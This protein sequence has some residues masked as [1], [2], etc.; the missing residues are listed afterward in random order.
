MLK[1]FVGFLLV[2]CMLIFMFTFVEAAD[3][4]IEQW[5]VVEI[6]FTSTN[7]YEE[8]YYDVSLDVTFTLSGGPTIKRP[9]FWDGGNTWR[10]RF[11][12]TQ[13]GIWNYSTVCS[14]TSNTGLH[15]KTGTV[16]C[17][18]YTGQMPIYQKGF[19]KQSSNSRYFTYND[20]TP[21]FWLA[22]DHTAIAKERWN[23]SNKP[24][25]TSQFRDTVDKRI[26]QGFTVYSP[27]IFLGHV[28]GV[29][30]GNYIDQNGF[31]QSA[32]INGYK[33]MD[34]RI[35]YLADKGLVISICS[36]GNF[37][38]D[39]FRFNTLLDF[40]EYT[41][42]N[43]PIGLY[44]EVSFDNEWKSSGHTSC[45]NSNGAYIDNSA[46]QTVKTLNLPTGKGLDQ[47]SVG[48]VQGT[49][50]VS[51][52]APGTS[53]A[54]VQAAINEGTSRIIST[55]WL[56]DS[57]SV[58]ITITN[59][60]GVNNIIFD[61][62]LYNYRTT[63]PVREGITDYEAFKQEMTYDTRY[64]LAR[65]GAYP[66][67]WPFV[68]EA[69]SYVSPTV[70]AQR[71]D[72]R[73]NAWKYVYQCLYSI[74]SQGY[75][76]PVSVWY[77]SKEYSRDADQV[78]EGEL[79]WP[80]YYAKDGLITYMSPQAVHEPDEINSDGPSR[81]YWF[82]YTQNSNFSLPVLPI[83]EEAAMWEK[84]HNKFRPEQISYD[85]NGK[86]S[87]DGY[88]ST[89][90]SGYGKHLEVTAEDTRLQAYRSM[91]CGAVGFHYGAQG[92]W[93]STYSIDYDNSGEA[94]YG[95]L[96]WYDGVDLPGAD[97]MAY[98]KKF[99]TDNNFPWWTLEPRYNFNDSNYGPIVDWYWMDDDER[100]P[101][102]KADS[103]R[104][105]VTIYY[106]A[107]AGNI[108]GTIHLKASTAYNLRWFNTREGRWMNE[109]SRTTDANGVFLLPVKP[110]GM[111]W[112]LRIQTSSVP[113]VDPAPT[114]DASMK[115]NLEL[116]EAT[117]TTAADTSGN[118]NNGTL[119]NG[120][121][122]GKEGISGN[123]VYFDGVDDYIQVPDSS[124][125]DG[126]AALTV[127]MWV[128]MPQLPTK[129]IANNQ[130]DYFFPLAKDSNGAAY[131][132]VISYDGVPHFA[133]QTTNNAW[134]T[135]GTM[136]ESD[137]KLMPNTWHH[138]AGTYDGNNVR[139]YIDGTLRAT[140]AS[141]I[142]GNIAD[143]SS[144]LNIGS[145]F[146]GYIDRVQIFNRA[147][148]PLE[149]QNNY[150]AV[151]A[152]LD[153]KVLD[154]EIDET[155]GTTAY[156]I[157]GKNNNGTLMNGTV[158][159]VE[160]IS[161]RAAYFDGVND[162]IELPDS[163]NI[164][165][166]AALTVSTWVNMSQLPAQGTYYQP[167][168]K[169]AG[170]QAYRFD[171]DSSGKPQFVVHTENNAWYSNGT[172]AQSDEAISTNAWHHIVGTYNGSNVSIYVDGVLKKTNSTAISGNIFDATSVLRI[173]RGSSGGYFKG[174]IDKTQIFKKALSPLEIYRLYYA[175]SPDMP[176]GM[177]LLLNDSSGSIA[178]D[179]SGN[180]N[181]GT[182][183]DNATLVTGIS[184]KAV[185]FDGAGDY[186]EVSDSSA[187][188]GMSELSV[189]AWINIDQIPSAGTYYLPIAKYAGSG[190]SYLFNIDSIGQPS[191][192]VQTTNNIWYTL[193][194]QATDKGVKMKPG[195]WYYIVGTYDGTNLRLYVN[196]W[197]T[198]Y[199]PNKI[200]GNIFNSAA[201]LIIGANNFKGKMDDI[202][203]YSKALTQQEISKNYFSSVADWK[204]NET[205]GN[206]AQ[207]SS[208][209]GLTGSLTGGTTFTS[210]G[211]FG[212][213][214][215]FDGID[216][217]I[218]IP[219]S[220]QL[221]GMPELTVSAWVDMNRLPA[222]GTYYHP[223]SKD[224]GSQAY[225]IDIDSSGRAQFVVHTENNA[226]YSNGTMV[227]SDI[228]LSTNTWHHIVGTYDGSN[229]SI[230]IDGVLRQTNSTTISENVFDATSVLRI[231][232]GSSGGYFNGK[233]DEVRI[234]NRCLLPNDVCNLFNLNQLE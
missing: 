7:T 156:D 159:G 229:V 26:Q 27:Y 138:I 110:D 47:I 91:Q 186:I 95:H 212:N 43:T 14:D 24:G 58:E 181:N 198:E 74:N 36:G 207:D 66:V 103:A 8:P 104:D 117:G 132:M 151:K 144:P 167:V 1:K 48:S 34:Q 163:P 173:G 172:I 82:Y 146:G 152:Q 116:D 148:T 68:G 164:D 45:I 226:W 37:T 176:V 202:K 182:L 88:K 70:S 221:D 57:P 185:A 187:L 33:D 142:S 18:Q 178:S 80:D 171:I 128:H 189:A 122:P 233:I 59:S 2:L 228:L 15:N 150:Y 118:N 9:A 200:S 119:L 105:N 232:R 177:E 32:T 44:K 12:P 130:Y 154:M 22:D 73:I 17:V 223:V 184:G 179:T 85:S 213:A 220:Y 4:T 78:Y 210:G 108:T 109:S 52:A 71:Y 69:G 230:Y 194:T 216:D 28:S 204:M 53:N 50:T 40:T 203:I 115:L 83:I 75:N 219:D 13:T 60:M 214:V 99:Y 126:M 147:L 190:R 61:D 49:A 199:V 131:R 79:I 5:R 157:S 166:M 227:Q 222:Q 3:Y 201:S 114:P 72:E 234:Y 92:V 54:V 170:S 135:T 21:F 188:A 96:A 63:Y 208:G 133:V 89:E 94:F 107:A 41:A 206:V 46:T 16:E 56:Y 6:T 30:D 42:A 193:G 112:A 180:N 217:Y 129:N 90:D 120:A 224:A 231:G 139:I 162:Y 113:S 169:D 137:I 196:G 183:V 101:N 20:G 55:G 191:F 141:T 136:V 225:R 39:Y 127:S 153:K 155:G 209:S 149:L 111:D 77:G 124:T 97:E 215:S 86:P 62:M 29:K 98:M 102:V 140:N 145:D 38:C 121:V 165:G 168:S 158:N 93:D 161:G 19:I 125:L 143:V 218:E 174:N 197:M 81:K 25:G 23:E 195:K 211:I 175:V 87:Y 35:Q 160:G 10:V 100:M 64:I 76:Q 205:S 51:I 123:A 11:A 31:T 192:V 65:Y 134:Y 84:M 106:P 67:V